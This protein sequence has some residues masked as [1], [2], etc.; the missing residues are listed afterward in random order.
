MLCG[1]IRHH[2]YLGQT[3][4]Q[5]CV[6]IASFSSFSFFFLN[7]VSFSFFLSR[8]NWVKLFAVCD[9]SKTFWDFHFIHS[10][11]S[12]YSNVVIK[13]VPVLKVHNLILQRM[14]TPWI[15]HIFCHFNTPS[16]SLPVPKLV[17][18]FEFSIHETENFPTFGHA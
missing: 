17:T 7:I 8:K 4:S 10:A 5:E 18:W 3:E 16:R 13:I 11:F 12:F 1:E 9:L 14:F 6:S 2:D 15:L